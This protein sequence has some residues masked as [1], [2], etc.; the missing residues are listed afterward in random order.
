MPLART[1]ASA[2]QRLGLQRKLI[3]LSVCAPY[4]I[5]NRHLLHTLCFPTTPSSASARRLR[6]TKRGHTSPQPQSLCSPSLISFTFST[7]D[8]VQESTLFSQNVRHFSQNSRHSSVGDSTAA[9]SNKSADSDSPNAGVGGGLIG[10]HSDHFLDTLLHPQTSSSRL[11]SHRHNRDMSAT[12]G[13]LSENIDSSTPYP[14]GLSVNEAIHGWGKTSAA[15]TVDELER[16]VDNFKSKKATAL[17]KL[18]ILKANPDTK[19]Q[20]L[21]EQ[22]WYIIRMFGP[23]LN[24]SDLRTAAASASHCGSAA[25]VFTLL[26]EAQCNGIH[27][28]QTTWNACLLCILKASAALQPL[29]PD[30][31]P[32]H[33]YRLLTN[34]NS[35]GTSKSQAIQAL[36][37]LY[38]SIQAEERERHAPEL[39]FATEHDAVLSQVITKSAENFGERVRDSRPFP[40]QNLH[41]LSS[42]LATM[43]ASGCPPDERTFNHVMSGVSRVL[44]CLS[45]TSISAEIGV[46]AAKAKRTKAR[47]DMAD[48]DVLAKCKQL[49]LFTVV[50]SK[51]HSVRPS[52]FVFLTCLHACAG[53]REATL[54]VWNTLLTLGSEPCQVRHSFSYAPCL[55]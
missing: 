22:L 36:R 32:V 28:Q 50:L 43:V 20:V 6:V 48:I 15:R 4:N 23:F 24:S 9:A 38:N 8:R 49:A 13:T 37:M 18:S 2:Q 5:L 29:G 1:T 42:C 46:I 11:D 30:T 53:D 7:A 16:L 39:Q 40:T 47:N 19:P 52:R 17:T 41:V 26:H 51:E 54:F 14:Q 44:S 12:N 34:G 31:Y 55:S 10:D 3:R 21:E 33:P 27:I 35:S 25:L 45:D